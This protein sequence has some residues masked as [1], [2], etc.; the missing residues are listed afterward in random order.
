MH[1]AR[2]VTNEDNVLDPM[3]EAVTR[4]ASHA[5]RRFRVRILVEPNHCLTKDILV[6]VSLLLFYILA[7]SKVKSEWSLVGT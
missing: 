1:S 6:A 5:C 4:Q 2:G 7:T 3:A